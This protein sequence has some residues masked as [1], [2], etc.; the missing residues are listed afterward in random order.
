MQPR[1]SHHVVLG[2]APAAARGGASPRGRPGGGVRWRLL[3]L[4]LQLLLLLLLLQLLLLL[5]QL[6]LLLL[7]LLLLLRGLPLSVVNVCLKQQHLLLRQ[8]TRHRRRHGRCPGPQ[9]GGGHNR[10]GQAYG[11][12]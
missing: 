5:L 11:L 10:A 4:L 12:C 7:P 3:P 6:L 8:L 1:H 2:P 9:R